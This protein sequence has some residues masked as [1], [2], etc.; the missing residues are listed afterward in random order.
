MSSPARRTLTAVVVNH[1]GGQDVERSVDSLLA[2]VGV[3]LEVVVVDNASSD[4]SPDRL[5]SRF[6]ERIRLLRSAR[7]LGFGAGNNLAIRQSDSELVL[8]LNPDA[9]AEP[10]LA[11]RL[12]AA[13]HSGERRGMAAPKVLLADSGRPPLIDTTGH[14]L[15]PDG[16]NRGRGRL[17]PD[18]G[19]FDSRADALFPSG[20]AALYRRAA[21]D[22]VGLFDESYFL[23]GDDAELG[24]RLRLAGWGCAFVPQ[25]VALHR[26]SRSVGAHSSLKA[27][28]VERNRIFVL[29]TLLPWSLI[30]ASPFWTTARLAVMAWGALTGRGAAARLRESRGAGE[31]VRVTLA[32][33]ASALAGSPRALARRAEVRRHAKL[34]RSEW[35]KLLRSYRLPLREVALND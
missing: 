24:L 21:L 35:S 18:L 5:A 12:I 8:L 32:A 27:F 1:D 26:Y 16:L 17:Q 4:G 31:L 20:A 3:D 13:L 22:E 14:L 25:A 11:A 10:E 29:L 6:G 2:Q 34:S 23:Y 28:Q 9:I 30:L 33:W 19:Q 7:N 15:Y